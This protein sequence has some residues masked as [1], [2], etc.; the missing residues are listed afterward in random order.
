MGKR[1]R[2]SKERQESYTSGSQFAGARWCRNWQKSHHQ[3]SLTIYRKNIQNSRGCA[4]PALCSEDGLHWECCKDYQR[5]NDSV[6][7]PFPVW[8]LSPLTPIDGPARQMLIGRIQ[9]R[10]DKSPSHHHWWNQSG[11]SWFAVWHTLPTDEGGFPKQGSFW[12]S[13]DGLFWRHYA[14]KACPRN[15]CFWRNPQ[16]PTAKPSTEHWKPVAQ[17][18]CYHIEDQS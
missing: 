1:L 3:R 12:R 10:L 9:E 8:Q 4:K 18:F 13:G 2:E 5:P 17:L 6:C 14:D 15:P 11:V 16:E 7:L